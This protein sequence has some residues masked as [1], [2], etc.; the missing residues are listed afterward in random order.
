LGETST[1]PAI[2]IL[3]SNLLFCGLEK[4][5]RLLKI[6]R[7]LLEK[8]KLLFKI[9]GALM[10]PRNKLKG[11]EKIAILEIMSVLIFSLKVLTSNLVF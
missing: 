1:A 8:P 3:G 9:G 5:E 10:H 4:T 7:S 6:M 2:S 11:V